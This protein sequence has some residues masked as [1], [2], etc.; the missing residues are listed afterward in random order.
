MNSKVLNFS[1]TMNKNNFSN[2]LNFHLALFGKHP[3]NYFREH[4]SS[5]H[6]GTAQ[7]NLSSGSPIS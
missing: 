1:R 3:E 2:L 5:N 7:D 6:F 4:Y